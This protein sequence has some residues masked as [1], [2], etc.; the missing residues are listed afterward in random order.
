MPSEAYD[1]V[2]LEQIKSETVTRIY[3]HPLEG[4]DQLA[5]ADGGRIDTSFAVQWCFCVQDSPQSPCLCR[6]LIVWLGRGDVVSYGTTEHKDPAG[7][8]LHFFD[9]KNDAELLLERVQPIG[10]AAVRR[11][12]G[13]SHVEVDKLLAKSTSLAGLPFNGPTPIAMDIS[14]IIEVYEALKEA[15]EALGETIDVQ[16]FVKEYGSRGHS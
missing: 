9:L 7:E 15:K 1:A 8:S 3:G 10:M 12:T 2:K 16:K 4:V 5:A 6:P 14:T 13:L 11:F